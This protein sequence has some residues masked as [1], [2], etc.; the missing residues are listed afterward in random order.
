MD[1]PNVIP[2]SASTRERAATLRELLVHHEYRYHVLD[3][4]EISDAEYDLLFRELKDLEATYPDLRDE[5]SPTLRVG[6]VVLAGLESRQHRLRMYS[7]DNVFSVQDMDEYIAKI[8]RLLPGKVPDTMAFWVD[9]KMD[10]L[11][12]ELIYENGIFTTALTRGDGEK[13]EIVTENMRTV[14]NIPLRLTGTN[15]PSYIEVR[16]EVILTRKDFEA[17]NAHQTA[18]GSKSFANPRNAAAGSVR[19]LDSRVTA[20]RPLRFMAYGV[21][22]VDDIP[23]GSYA[24]YEELMRSLTTMGFATAPEAR[25]CHNPA[26][27]GQAFVELGIKRHSLP[28][29]IDGVVAKVNDCL[30]HESLGFTA[31]APRWAVALK[32]PAIQAETTLNTITIQVGRTGVLTPVAEL[33]A[34]QVGGVTVS[35]ATLHNEDEIIAKDIRI[36]DTVIVQR[37][38]DVI[39]EVV[40][41]VI[42]KR[43]ITSIPFVFPCICPVCHEKVHREE[44]QAA[45]RC[46]NHLCPA[47]VREAVIFFASKGGL[48]IQGIGRRWIEELVDRGMVKTFADLFRLQRES[49][50]ELPRMGAKLADNFLTAL[51]HA[52]TS[53]TLPRFITALGIRHV[54]E[55]T[56]KALAAKYHS[57]DALM[58]A[59]FESLQTVPDVGPEVADAVCRFFDTPG[60]R[61]LLSELKII[62]LWPVM[63]EDTPTIAQDGPLTNKTLLFTGTL[64]SMTR[65]EAE[66]HAEEAGGRTV[67]GVS[68]KLDILVVGGSPGSKVR[69]AE[70]LGIAIW[71]EARFLHET[72]TP[73]KCTQVRVEQLSLL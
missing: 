3:D 20:T 17:L 44:G 40:R 10:G 62:G 68:K 66:K 46:L 6:G 5:S 24:T 42:E 55:Q 67:S 71:D 25:L 13:G 12:M 50:L 47:V 28:F 57:M 49:L 30:L 64:S 60:N 56:A 51:E 7:L 18:T 37:A 38:G 16:G 54:G 73:K 63:P 11:A 70:A 59:G 32:F 34:V 52:K 14:K 26:E 72:A 1:E 35:R 53:S 39:P 27:V 4:P 61:V 41:P 15:V 36:G 48:D 22:Y 8:V 45:W 31:K 19:Q 2:S 65:D 29:E 69:K 21:G 33:E 43:S 58:E 23:G 9:P